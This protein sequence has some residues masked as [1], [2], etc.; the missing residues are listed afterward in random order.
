[1]TNNIQLLQVFTK[2]LRLN[3]LNM[4]LKEQNCPNPLIYK[5]IEKSKPIPMTE[6]SFTAQKET[7]I[8]HIPFV[9]T[10]DP[11]LQKTKNFKKF[12]PKEKILKTERQSRKL[13]KVLTRVEFYD[14]TGIRYNISK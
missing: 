5:G 9:S 11:F 4:F 8:D 6:L 13:K 12:F 1:M 10:H 7:T 2:Y 14:P 3:E